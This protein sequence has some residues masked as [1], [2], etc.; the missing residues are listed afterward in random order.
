MKLYH[1]LGIA[2]VLQCHL[3]LASGD[4]ANEMNN[5][6]DDDVKNE[7]KVIGDGLR[8]VV[9]TVQSWL[10]NAIALSTLNDQVAKAVSDPSRF[11]YEG[12]DWSL[13]LLPTFVLIKLAFLAGRNRVHNG[14]V[15]FKILVFRNLFL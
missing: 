2:S 1:A 10:V 12:I 9:D 15:A 4:D 5:N 7:L 14:K 11:F 13:N 3:S 8:D 6:I